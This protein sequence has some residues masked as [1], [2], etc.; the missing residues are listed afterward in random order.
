MSSNG[1]LTT[2]TSSM[3]DSP[4]YTSGDPSDTIDTKLLPS[5]LNDADT[6]SDGEP[7][8]QP[9]RVIVNIKDSRDGAGLGMTFSLAFTSTFKNIF[10]AFKASS[11]KFCKPGTSMRFKVKEH[12]VHDEYTPE[13]VSI[14]SDCNR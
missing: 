9:K 14:N 8:D 6:E 11:C 2:P 3:T 12:R 5:T 10:D 1:N 7:S 4:T 13:M